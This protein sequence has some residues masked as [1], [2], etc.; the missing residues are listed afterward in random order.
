MKP[1]WIKK[2]N[3]KGANPDWFH[4]PEGEPGLKKHAL[5]LCWEC[6]VR[7]ECFLYAMSF[8]QIDDQYGIYGG[9]TPQQRRQIRRYAGETY[10]M[11]GK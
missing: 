4:P 11:R 10:F 6:T 1:A 3:C 8:G 5:K 2:A 7:D 9:T